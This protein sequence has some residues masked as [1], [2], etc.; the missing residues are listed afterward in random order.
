MRRVLRFLGIGLVAVAVLLILGTV[1]VY[2]ITEN[3]MNKTFE[4][5]V[6]AVTIPTDDAALERGKYLVETVGL[7]QDCH[8]DHYG[9]KA[10]FDE[11]GLGKVD[12]ANLTSG[13]GGVGSTFTDE[14]WVRVLR[15]G[16]GQDGKSLIIMPSYHYQ[17]FSDEDLGAVIAYI[18][19]VPPVDFEPEEPSIALLRLFMLLDEALSKDILPAHQVDFDYD[20]P[21]SIEPSVSAEYGEYLASIACSS[22]HGNDYAGQQI[23]PGGPVSANLTPGGDVADY[24]AFVA[25]VRA[26]V[27]HDGEVMDT[28]EMPWN[29]L[30]N[31]TDEDLEAIWLFLQ[32][33]PS[34]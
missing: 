14:D 22:C 10:F 31:L 30:T 7:C 12:S 17:V 21:A 16:V 3:R 8:G 18:K 27:R 13:K 11:P 33:L 4:V 9:G 32:T 34:K 26:G 25:A 29:R 5:Q 6:E 2:A 23:G 20:A 24:A 1:A 19:T 15:Y 28:E